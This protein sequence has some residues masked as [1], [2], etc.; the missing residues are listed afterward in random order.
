MF[1]ADGQMRVAARKST[2]MKNIQVDVSQHLTVSPAAVIWTLE[3]PTHGTVA[4]FISGFKIWLSLRLSGA[5][6]YFCFDQYHDYSTKSSNRFARATNSRVLHFTLTTP[7]PAQDTVLKNYTNKARLN[8]LICEQVL[9]D[10]DFLYNSMQNHKL[11]VTENKSEPTQVS[12]GKKL[13]VWISLQCMKRL[14]SFLLNKPS[15]LQKKIPNQESLW[16]LMTLTY[17]LCYCTSTGMRS[18]NQQ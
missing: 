16:F 12:K 1:H 10:N 4:T 8:A 15:I 6:V 3:W 13:P 11:V 7:L 5:D 17:S 14:T 18:F 9:S 2:L